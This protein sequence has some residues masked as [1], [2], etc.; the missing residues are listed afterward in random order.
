MNALARVTL[1]RV[2]A[3]TLALLDA[4]GIGG[5]NLVERVGCA[6]EE[7]ACIAV[8]TKQPLTCIIIP[9]ISHDECKHTTKYVPADP[10]STPPT[11]PCFHSGIFRCTS[12]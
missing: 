2:L 5:D 10:S 8:T 12:T 1:V 9:T 3:Q 6:R 11:T 4:Q 7:L